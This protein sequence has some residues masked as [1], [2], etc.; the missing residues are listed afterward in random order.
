[1]S[2]PS[3]VYITRTN[4]GADWISPHANVYLKPLE[5][6]RTHALTLCVPR[7]AQV[8]PELASRCAR[9]VR[10]DS[11]RGLRKRLLRETSARTELFT[12]FDFPC[13]WLARKLKRRRGCPW[14]VFLWDPP[15]L[16]HRD[17]FPPLRRAIDFVWRMLAPAADRLVLNIHPGLLGE[18]RYRPPRGQKLEFRMQDAFTERK[19]AKIASASGCL[20]D[21]GVLSNW[22]AAKG[23]PLLS[24]AL[25]RLPGLKGLWIGS[26][27]AHS[28]AE[29]IRFTGRLPQA[30]AF[31]RLRTCRV[32]IVP[33]LPVPS[34]KWN[35]PLKLFEYLQ[36]GRPVVASDNP[37]NAAVAA[38]HPRCVR[39]FKSGDA[40]S[41][42]AV[43]KEVLAESSSLDVP[44]P[45]QHP[46]L[47][48]L[49][50][51]SGILG[52][53]WCD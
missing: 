5:V 31:A 42:A 52:F 23:G 3:A 4:L 38:R 49:P 17:A 39:L 18:M 37:G 48:K 44:T 27:P 26:P 28:A 15:S 51:L 36:L 35:Y 40:A 12:G 11:L 30:E 43:L 34:L 46:V 7:T 8:P 41:L 32:L 6:A 33:Y 24:E 21:F 1:M 16:G 50:V 53:P 25:A 9:L 45:L 20:Y 29:G 47:A 22:T 13:L 2:L 14:T 19:P 10:Y